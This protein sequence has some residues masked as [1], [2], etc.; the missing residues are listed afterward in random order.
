[1]QLENVIP[2]GRSLDEY[3]QMF[4]LTEADLDGKILSIADGPASVNA[5]LHA[6]GKNYI[7]MDPLYRFG[8]KDI[9]AQFLRVADDVFQQV[10]E[11]LDKWVWNYHP[12]LAALKK[13]RQQVLQ[14]FIADL[15]AGIEKKRYRVGELPH[16]EL[17]DNAFDLA[18]CSHFLFLYSEL[19]DYAFHRDSIVE[20][21]RVAREIRIFPLLTLKQ[22]RSP[23][24]EPL[25]EELQK[26][27]YSVS[28][29]KVPYEFQKGGNEMLRI[30]KLTGY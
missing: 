5:E 16:L 4:V 10:E 11:T 14:D 24:L 19:F 28:I 30:G 6:Q 29:E 3:R 26:Q 23:Y 2:F 20:L 17:A 12:T 27:A 7:S 21:L 18:L 9:E 1:M 15:P 22:Q 8:A 25:L 13:Q